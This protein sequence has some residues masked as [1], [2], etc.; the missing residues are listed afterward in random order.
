MSL[1]ADGYA[2]LEPVSSFKCGVADPGTDPTD[3][4]LVCVHFNKEWL[5]LVLGSLL[6]LCEP[7]SWAITDP[8]TLA[9]VL[10]RATEL[11]N[12]FGQAGLCPVQED[13][14]LALTIPAGD[15]SVS[16][17]IVFSLTYATPPLVDCSGD[18]PDLIAT[19]GDV[20]TF[21]FTLTITAA[22]PVVTAT[23]ANVSWSTNS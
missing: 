17:D 2:A 9:D 11:L 12:L 18:N 13:G 8:G 19:W 15:A 6:Q 5:P 10:G 20:T 21:G 7:V 1:W 4:P 14:V 23:M 22:T 3:G 16:G